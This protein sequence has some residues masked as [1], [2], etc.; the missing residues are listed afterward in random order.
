MNIITKTLII[1]VESK[2]I[3][4]N[5]KVEHEAWELGEFNSIQTSEV[6]R[7]SLRIK[8]IYNHVHRKI[9]NGCFY[10]CGN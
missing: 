6:S 7:N 4:V 5:S 1:L 8:N 2:E 3:D 9:Q 10:Y